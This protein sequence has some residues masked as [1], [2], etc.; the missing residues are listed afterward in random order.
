MFPQIEKHCSKICSE[1]STWKKKDKVEYRDINLW[2]KKDLYI[3]KKEDVKLNK[4]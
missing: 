2:L 4:D 3:K 1:N